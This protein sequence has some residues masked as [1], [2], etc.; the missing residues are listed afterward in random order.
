M[1]HQEAPSDPVW[2]GLKNSVNAEGPLPWE[3]TLKE[4]RVVWTERKKRS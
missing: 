2:S 3:M 1:S 4:F